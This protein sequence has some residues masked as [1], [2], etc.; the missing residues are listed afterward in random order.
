M[1]NII[2]VTN[3]DGRHDNHTSHRNELPPTIRLTVSCV[4]E[5]IFAGAKAVAEPTMRVAMAATNFI[6]VDW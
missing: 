5:E 6:L 2:T 1:R 3:V 4:L